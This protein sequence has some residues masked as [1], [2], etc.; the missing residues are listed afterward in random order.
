MVEE[1]R[2]GAVPALAL[3]RSGSEGWSTERRPLSAP[4]HPWHP[5]RRA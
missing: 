1:L 5:L 4:A 3:P 2:C